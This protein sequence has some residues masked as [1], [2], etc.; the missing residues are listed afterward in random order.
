MSI[1]PEVITRNEHGYWSHSQYPNWDDSV[2]VKTMHQWF[3]D[4]GLCFQV[5]YFENDVSEEKID[6]FFGKGDPDVTHWQPTIPH[7]D[8]FLLSIHDMESG[9]VAVWAVHGEQANTKTA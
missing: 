6:R 3:S 7:P 8:A 4:R 2:D 5:V 9:P 1:K